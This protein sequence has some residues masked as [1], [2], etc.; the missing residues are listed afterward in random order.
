M[1]R[2]MGALGLCCLILT[3]CVDQAKRAEIAAENDKARDLDVRLIGEVTEVGNGG[4]MRVDGVG[5]VTRLQGTGHCPIG[6]YRNLMEQE[7]LKHSGSKGG[8]IN[9]LEPRVQVRQVLDDPCN[10][11]V[12]VTGFIPAGARKGD[13]FDVHLRLAE[14]SKATSLVGGYLELCT[15]RVYQAE[16]ALAVDPKL[17]GS[18]NLL[19][20]HIYAHAKGALVVGF[21]NNSDPNEL[22]HARVWQGGVSHIDRPYVFALKPDPQSLQ[23]ASRVATRM[24]SMYQEDPQVRARQADFSSEEKRLLLQGYATAQLNGKDAYGMGQGDVAKASKDSIIYVRVPTNYRLD[25]ARFVNIASL[26]P[27]PDVDQD[28]SRYVQRLQK[29]LLDPRDTRRAAFRLEAL[30]RDR[31]IPILQTGLENT[32][33]FVRFCSAESMAYL[34]NT[35][36]VDALIGLAQKH[37]I[38]AKHATTALANLGENICRDRLASLFTSD[39]PA[40]RCAAFHALTQIDEADRRLGPFCPNEAFWLYRVPQAPTRMVYFSTSKRPQIVLFGENIVFQPGKEGMVIGKDFTIAHADGANQ[41]RIKRIT[42]NGEQ[43]RSSS[44][45]LGEILTNLAYLGAS[46]TDIVDFLRKANDYQKVNCPIVAWTTPDVPQESL[47][48]EGRNLK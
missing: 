40:L 18:R 47:V 46:Y 31:A 6:F 8:E 44:G 10:A 17:Q 33:P 1:L 24:N 19:Q 29:M 48:E 28:L 5:L 41:F 25:H 9:H 45:N 22:K 20:G 7:L 3:C 15:L 37:P 35:A 30:G 36:G 13:R 12:I 21:G 2:P 38:L 27:L 16:G 26:T 42:V 34:G 14:D 39:E 32:H 11:L 4:P 43:Q 23:I